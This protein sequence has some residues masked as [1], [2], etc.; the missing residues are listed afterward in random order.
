VVELGFEDIVAAEIGKTGFGS[1]R[2]LAAAKERPHISRS[3]LTA[4]DD[5]EF[6]KLGDTNFVSYKGWRGKRYLAFEALTYDFMVS[7]YDVN[8]P[9]AYAARLFDP[10]DLNG[11]LKR[12]L[13]SMRKAVPNI[14]A[15]VIGLQNKEDHAFLN[16]MLSM[17]S[18]QGVR[19]IEADLF[20]NE[21]RHIAI[22]LKTGTSFNILLED[23]HYRPGEL[24][25]TMTAD[26]FSRALV[27]AKEQMPDPRRS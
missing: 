22:D 26:D 19:L 20:G 23:R 1:Q 8:S 5:A 13:I 15:R 3:K 21:T 17:F 14:E 24:T 10:K 7:L 27:K 11:I 16:G 12:D 6:L 4:H 2:Y 18:K 25:N 9:G